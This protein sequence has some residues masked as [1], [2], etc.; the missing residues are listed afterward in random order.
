MRLR[1]CIPLLV[2][3]ATRSTTADR[4]SS[5]ADLVSIPL[6]Q[7]RGEAN[8]AHQALHA[9]AKH[10]GGRSKSGYALEPEVLD[11]GFW[12]GAFDVGETKNLSLLIDTG[13]PDVAVNPNLY[14]PSRASLDLNETGA[15]GYSTVQEDGCG[16]ANISYQTFADYVSQAGLVARNQTL[17]NV[18]ATTP[19]NNGTITQFP[20][21]GIVGFSVP[22][23]NRTQTGGKPFFRTLCDQGSVRECRFGLAYGIE[24]TGTQVL[25]GIDRRLIDGNLETAP[26]NAVWEI[27]ANVAVNGS[28]ALSNQTVLFDS[29]TAN[30]SLF[31]SRDKIT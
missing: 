18:V 26:T 19:P 5:H 15:L 21:Q 25:G 7:H 29:G 2:A 4:H 14:K 22:P 28:S 16:V 6:T 30:V 23:N 8:L 9:F 24:G 27:Q 20:H 13:S 11:A 3:V 12:Y 1:A 10:S 17:A 31:H